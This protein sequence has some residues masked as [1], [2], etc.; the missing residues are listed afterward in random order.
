MESKRKSIIFIGLIA[1]LAGIMFMG[2]CL[3]VGDLT[4]KQVPGVP[5]GN[6]SAEQVR[7]GL[8]PDSIANVVD[9]AGPAVVKIS[10]TKISRVPDPFFDDP[11]FRYFFGDQL[12]P[13][14]QKETGL[15]SGFIISEDG[16]VITNEH[17]ISGATDIKVTIGGKGKEYP[18]K[19]VGADYDLD[20]AVLKIQGAKNLPCLKMGDSDKVKVGNW[21]IAIGNPFGFDHTVT[22][23]VISA[24][25]RP[26]TVENRHY[27]NLLQT[28]AAINP[29]NSGGPLLNLKGEVIGI[30]TAV[31]QA[32]GIGFAIPTN[33]VK[34]VLD[35]LLTQ[36]KVSHPWLG[37]QM[38]DLSSD[39]AR[40]FG[41]QS[42]DG[43]VVVGVI[44]GSPAE[45]AGLQQMDIILELD[46]K[47]IKNSEEMAKA[48]K[49]MKIGQRANLLVYRKGRL[50]NISFTVGEKPAQLR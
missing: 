13:R 39:L 44:P 18:A 15:G 31:A 45:K 8:G 32:Q 43:V 17:V 19:V 21:V 29:G 12:L 33:T 2:G 23:G 42:T 26:V 22:V 14:T 3:L 36:G 46:G 28:D 47:N 48:I 5:G 34:E 20:L 41:L 49:D 30:N 16:L 11:F 50:M 38:S 37:I 24:K 25:G 4:G 9:S 35:E 40:Y 27:K 6:A 10:T 7:P 1:F